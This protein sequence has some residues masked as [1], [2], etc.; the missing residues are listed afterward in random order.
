MEEDWYMYFSKEDMCIP[1]CL[2]ERVSLEQGYSKDCT[3]SES[4]L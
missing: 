2:Q 3:C 1:Q 4:D